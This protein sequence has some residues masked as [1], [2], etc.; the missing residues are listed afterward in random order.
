MLLTDGL[1]AHH[2]ARKSLRQP[3]L[4]EG[5]SGMAFFVKFKELPG[6][7]QRVIIERRQ[8]TAPRSTTLK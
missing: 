8:E 4:Q 1:L 7:P 5:A 2:N 3:N 6:V